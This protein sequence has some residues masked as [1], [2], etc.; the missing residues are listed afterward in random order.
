[1]RVLKL[2][3]CLLPRMSDSPRI[4]ILPDL[5]AVARAAADVVVAA[6]AG[7]IAQRGVFHLVLSGGSTPRALYERLASEYSPGQLQL[8]AWRFYFG[9]ERCVPPDHADSNYRMAH[10]ALLGRVPLAPEQVQRLRGEDEAPAAAA[11]YSGMLRERFGD[12]AGPDLVLLG[13]GDDGH[14][15]S[16]FP[17]SDAILSGEPCVARFIAKLGAWRLT[18]TP[19][20][21]NRAG[22][23][24]LLVCGASKARRVHE[25]LRGD[26]EPTR[27][28]VQAIRP[29]GGEVT[30][31]LD[32]AA[33]GMI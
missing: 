23:V 28:P 15:A 31:L 21:I 26:R 25:V 14:T 19:A 30:W 33:G 20:F 32:G 2:P 13:M 27:L 22:A 1:M 5:H 16:L 3:Q 29:A 11:A 8:P 18:L 6:A 10:E 7:A 17:Q 9:D 12:A 4:R 24:L